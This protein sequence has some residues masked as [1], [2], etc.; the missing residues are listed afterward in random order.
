MKRSLMQSRMLRI[1]AVAAVFAA[2]FSIAAPMK[3]TAHSGAKGIVKERMDAMKEMQQAMKALNAMLSGEQTMNREAAAG[4]AAVIHTRAG[5]TMTSQFPPGSLDH[6]SEALPSIWEEW[7]EF[8]RQAA[9]LEQDASALLEALGKSGAGRGW[10][11][12]FKRVAASCKSC[13][14]DFKKR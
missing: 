2:V 11:D 4:H 12:Q 13:H 14:D 5:G 10:E 1:A 7:P 3:S 8:E 6:P 9:D